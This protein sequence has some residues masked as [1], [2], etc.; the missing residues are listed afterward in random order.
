MCFFFLSF[1]MVLV[2][3]YHK[4]FSHLTLHVSENWT[5]TC[6]T[7]SSVVQNRKCRASP[8]VP[9]ETQISLCHFNYLRPWFL[10]LLC[11]SRLLAVDVQMLNVL[12]WL[13]IKEI[14]VM[15]STNFKHHFAFWYSIAFISLLKE[16]NIFPFLLMTLM[17]NLWRSRFQLLH[18]G[19]RSILNVYIA[20]NFSAQTKDPFIAS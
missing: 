4:S 3:C 9:F 17:I 7:E 8:L 13:L 16:V 1:H 12:T 20:K 11:S 5:I 2:N 10:Q 15:L 19:M 18:L 6:H 14:S